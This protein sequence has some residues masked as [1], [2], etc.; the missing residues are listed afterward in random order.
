MFL[1]RRSA[2]LARDSARNVRPVQV[3]KPSLLTRKPAPVLMLPSVTRRWLTSDVK[4]TTA[5]PLKQE[6]DEERLDPEALA[7]IEADL[8]N[9][10]LKDDESD[11][12]WFVDKGYEQDHPEYQQNEFVPLWQRRAAGDSSLSSAAE[13]MIKERKVNLPSVLALLE[14]NKAENIGVIDMRSKCDWTDFMIVA[15]SSRGERF[16]NSIADEVVSVLGKAQKADPSMNALPKPSIE[17]KNEGSDWLL[18]D[19]GPF[20]IHLFTPQARVQYDLEGLWSNVPDDP[21]LRIEN[22]G[23][24]ADQLKEKVENSFGKTITN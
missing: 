9:M 15:E 2:L 6:V 21:L 13:D 16:L 4:D 18:V 11:P 12:D 22:S 3:A 19:A 7:A 23:L 10:E 1:L 14:E 5:S 20:I 8:E 17:G 24:N